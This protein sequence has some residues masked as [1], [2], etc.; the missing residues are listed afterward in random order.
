MTGKAQ[1]LVANLWWSFSC[2]SYKR[3]LHVCRVED[4]GKIDEKSR[5]Y[6]GGILE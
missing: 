4:F 1:I 6:L 5:I 3:R 2:G